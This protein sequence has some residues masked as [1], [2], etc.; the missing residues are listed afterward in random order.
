VSDDHAIHQQ[1]IA[2]RRAYL[3]ALRGRLAGG[4]VAG[5]TLKVDECLLAL[6]VLDDVSDGYD[7]R[8]YFE[9][10][11][12]PGERAW[13]GARDRLITL[14]FLRLTIDQPMEKPKRHRVTVAKEMGWADE[15]KDTGVKRVGRIVSEQQNRM[16][17]IAEASIT[18][19]ILQTLQ[20]LLGKQDVP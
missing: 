16:K 7:A 14:Y 5:V 17:P 2:A 19:E 20:I 1:H 13:C 18:A 3:D 15:P 12:K 8:K 9:I 6:R 11:H 10:S 4:L